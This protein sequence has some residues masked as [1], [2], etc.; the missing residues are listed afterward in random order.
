MYVVLIFVFRKIRNLFNVTSGFT[1]IIVLTQ[2][3][4][5]KF[6]APAN[7]VPISQKY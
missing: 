6:T 3:K 1:R 5:W 4:K 7:L 2:E